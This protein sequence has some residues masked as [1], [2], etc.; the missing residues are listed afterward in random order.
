M[1]M[2]VYQRF[3]DKAT[4]VTIVLSIIAT[5]IAVICIYTYEFDQVNMFWE[6]S[7]PCIETQSF[8]CLLDVRNNQAIHKEFLL[9]IV[10]LNL[11]II[12]IVFGFLLVFLFRRFEWIAKEED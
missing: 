2:K 10:G 9:T 12:G 7:K 3:G 1:C 5:F 4:F 8:Q 6:M 11:S